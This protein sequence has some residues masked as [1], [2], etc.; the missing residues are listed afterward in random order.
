MRTLQR[1]KMICAKWAEVGDKALTIKVKSLL[2]GESG[3][4]PLDYYHKL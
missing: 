2:S 3:G 4:G 1:K